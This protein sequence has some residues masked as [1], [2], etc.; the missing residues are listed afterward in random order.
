MIKSIENTL[1]KKQLLGTLLL[2]SVVLG[3]AVSYKELYLLHLIL[4]VVM[5]FVLVNK[6]YRNSLI[7]ILKKPINLLLILALFWF[8]CSCFWA[9][10]KQY[11]LISVMQFSIGL[12]IVYLIQIFIST[13]TEFDFY[14]NKVFLPVLIVVIGIAM[15]E[16]YTSFRWPLS[17][18]SYHNNWFGR[19]N[20]VYD[21]LKT[22]LIPGYLLSSPTVF[23]WNPN[24]LAVFLC[25][26]IP[27][28][29]K[30]HWKNVILFILIVIVI[31]QTGSRLTAISLGL[32]LLLF[33]L[34]NLRYLK[35]FGLYLITLLIPM[36]F[37]S[38]SLLAIKSNEPLEKISGVNVLSFVQLLSSKKIDDSIQPDNSQG[39][40]KQLYKQ[41][42]E[43]VKKTKFI[44]V[45]SGNAEWHNYKQKENTQEVTSVHFYWLELLINGGIV[46]GILFLV[47]FA[48]MYLALWKS[49]KDHIS[50]VL[51]LGLTLFGIAVISLSSA[52]YYLPYYAFI[53][54]ITAWINLKE[55]KNETSVAI[56]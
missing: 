9:E 2:I 43:Y 47:Y 35:F 31:I 32:T 40:R 36:M 56:S 53:G 3:P 30:N 27:F 1:E 33:S 5:A 46:I 42:F 11:A 50:E 52:H 13:R 28:V 45:G 51:L 49:R 14:K 23:F 22:E 55:A 7:Q 39:I 24:N 25:F 48:K 26:F 20:V 37:F 18:I 16:S 41:G 54:I 17:S 38:S 19:E 6:T 21:N 12:S 10:N 8:G 44:G 34:I 4:V 29:I 15:L